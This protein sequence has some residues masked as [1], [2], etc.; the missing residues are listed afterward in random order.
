MFTLDPTVMFISLILC[1]I[2]TVYY[3]YGKKK[4]P[5]FRISGVCLFLFPFFITEI[6]WLI[7]IGV[8]LLVLPFILDRIS[9]L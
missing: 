4:S 7:G 6:W 2:G 1:A 9:P 8:S 5:Y 3:A